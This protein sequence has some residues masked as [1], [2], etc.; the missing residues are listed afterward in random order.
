MIQVKLRRFMFFFAIYMLKLKKAYHRYGNTVL[1][2]QNGIQSDL[3]KLI[4]STRE[5]LPHYPDNLPA[6]ENAENL[7]K[8]FS[9]L[10][11]VTQKSQL[12]KNLS[13]FIDP[14][15]VSEDKLLNFRQQSVSTL[16]KLYA[17]D[18]IFPMSTGGSTG[19][20]LNFYIS[21]NRG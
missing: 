3:K 2:Q 13:A 12:K 17:D 15:L 4:G 20:P 11:F 9:E 7:V 21:K 6:I 18:V 8:A 14:S 1:F 5:H 10:D 16:F 19:S